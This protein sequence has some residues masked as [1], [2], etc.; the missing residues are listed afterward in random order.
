MKMAANECTVILF[1]ISLCW[2]SQL[3]IPTSETNE[4]LDDSQKGG[5]IVAEEQP[6]CPTWYILSTM[7]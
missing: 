4:F 7:E 6:Q 1:M 3:A 5:S 2:G